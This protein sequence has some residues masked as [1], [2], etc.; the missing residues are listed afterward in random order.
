LP[1]K[2]RCDRQSQEVADALNLTQDQEAEFGAILTLTDDRFEPSIADNDLFAAIRATLTMSSSRY[3]LPYRLTTGSLRSDGDEPRTQLPIGSL[4]P[5][6]DAAPHVPS[7]TTRGDR[8]MNE[9]NKLEALRSSL[10]ATDLDEPEMHALASQM[11]VATVHD[12][13]V[14]VAEGDIRQTLFLQAAGALQLYQDRGGNA[15]VLYQLRVGECVGT[16]TFIEGAPYV[17][18]LRSI[19]DSTVL[20]LEPAALESLAEVHP[21][22]PYKVMRAFVLITHGNLT[23]LFLEGAELRNYVLKTGGRY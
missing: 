14:L 16:R 17:F 5:G 6:P 12:G 3:W 20:T 15:E 19:G 22:L 1:P 23:R 11:A 21:R 18:G 2:Q 8:L 4:N 10:L 13:E 9:V 7:A